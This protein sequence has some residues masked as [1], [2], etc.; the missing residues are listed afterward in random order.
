MTQ[1]GQ[2]IKTQFVRLIIMIQFLTVIPVRK[3]FQTSLQDYGKGMVYAPLTGFVIGLVLLVPALVSFYL[4][5]FYACAVL[6]IVTYIYMTGGL[7][8]DGL[9]DTADGLMSNRSKEKILEIMKDSRIGT[10]AA[11]ALLSV[12]ITD[13]AML[14]VIFEKSKNTGITGSLVLAVL[15]F[16]VAGRTGSLIGAG[17]SRYARSG[18]SL[19][20]SFIEY[21]GKEQ[22]IQG[23]I[24][25]TVVFFLTAFITGTN[26]ISI[27]FVLLL[28]LPIITA[29]ILTKKLSKKL[30]GA[31]GD[32]L[33]AVCELNQMIFLIVFAVLPLN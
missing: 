1:F 11:L 32:I 22:I 7:H 6:T 26:I 5:P 31:T 17:I 4:L 3:S 20:K 21:C 14:A 33:G 8:M 9:G 2:N 19:G 18:E 29:F 28:T 23:L 15:L 12:I 25:Y 16:P 10:M 24:P 30:D 27:Y 13:I